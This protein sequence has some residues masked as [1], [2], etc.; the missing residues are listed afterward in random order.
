LEELPMPDLNQIKQGK[1][2][3][4]SPTIGHSAGRPRGCRDHMDREEGESGMQFAAD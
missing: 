4:V 1:Q 3:A 2:E